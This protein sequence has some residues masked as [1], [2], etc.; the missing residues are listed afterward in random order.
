MA[1]ARPRA[2]PDQPAVVELTRQLGALLAEL[3]LG[4]IEVAVGDMRIR[5][6]R[7]AVAAGP[8]GAVP[9]SAPAGAGLAEAGSAGAITVESP[10]VG[11]FYRAASPAAEAY[12]R[13]GDVVKDG[14]PLFLIEPA[15]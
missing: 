6:A 1:R 12:V 15:R 10:M 4:E 2:A 9:A 7:A 13:E 11:T 5:L 3:G 8:G 14:Q